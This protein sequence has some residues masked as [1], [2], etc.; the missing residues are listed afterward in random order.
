MRTNFRKIS[1][2]K[3]NKDFYCG[4]SPERITMIRSILRNIV[5]LVSA[6]NNQIFN[7]IDNL[8]NEITDAGTFRVKNIKTAESC[9]VI[10]N[11]QRDLNIAFVNELTNF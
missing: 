7:I 4:Y 8:Y 3:Y 5:K 1:K 6:S 10:E 9:K 2:L 11:A